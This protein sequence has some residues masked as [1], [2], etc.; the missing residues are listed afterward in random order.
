MHVIL[1][2]F[3]LFFF[4]GSLNS[5]DVKVSLGVELSPSLGV[6]TIKPIPTRSTDRGV[7]V[8]DGL[9]RGTAGID[10]FCIAADP[11]SLA[12][13][14]LPICWPEPVVKTGGTALLLDP[15]FALALLRFLPH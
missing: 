11:G 9:M 3:F 7:P 4:L 13:Q 5:A 10:A 14:G 8:T 1:P 12:E 2:L 6:D 15:E